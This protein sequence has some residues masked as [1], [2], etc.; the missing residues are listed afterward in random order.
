[1][2]I[3]MF[4]PPGAGKGTQSALLVEKY[5]LKHISTGDLFRYNIKNQTELGLEAKS[6]IDAGDLVPD[7]V[8]NRMVEQ[9]LNNLHQGKGFILDGF[10]RNVAQAEELSKML[11]TNSSFLNKVIFFEVPHELLL[12]RLTGRRICKKC[13]AVYHITSKPTK[14]DS[15]C[16]VCGGEVVQRADDRVDAIENRLKVYEEQTSPVKNFYREKGLLA[17]VD[18]KGTT[19]EVFNRVSA[20]LN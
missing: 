1:M 15:V 20:V 7:S 2:N 13:G 14:I 9:E 5:N 11:N 19:D 6:Y 3:L 12:D 10:P 18:G 16:D 4:G 8:T 17:E